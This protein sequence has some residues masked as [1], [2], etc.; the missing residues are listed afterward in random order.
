MEI[1]QNIWMA[2]TTENANLTKKESIGLGNHY[3]MSDNS[4]NGS[5]VFLDDNLIHA[6]YF[7][8]IPKYTCEDKINN[9]EDDYIFDESDISIIE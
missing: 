3:I 2:L 5:I 1:I 7:G 8:M 9:H 6:I 4:Y